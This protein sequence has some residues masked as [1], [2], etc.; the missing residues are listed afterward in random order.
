MFTTLK[1]RTRLDPNS[2]F[3]IYLWATSTAL[4][5]E[6]LT[7]GFPRE[8]R[9]ISDHVRV[10]KENERFYKGAFSSVLVL[11]C[12]L[13]LEDLKMPSQLWN[14][15]CAL[16]FSNPWSTGRVCSAQPNI[17]IEN[18]DSGPRYSTIYIQVNISCR[19]WQWIFDR[20]LQ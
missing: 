1:A 9:T 19:S 16:S 8:R 18:Q 14:S 4:K 7:T 2:K 11:A 12:L 10:R 13:L 15:Q 3:I 17:Y 6:N 5:Y 20:L